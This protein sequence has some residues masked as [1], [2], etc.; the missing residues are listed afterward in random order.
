MCADIPRYPDTAG[1]MLH[2]SPRNLRH[3]LSNMLWEDEGMSYRDDWTLSCHLSGI[4]SNWEMV[5]R[6]HRNTV[7]W[8]GQ[9]APP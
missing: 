7:L 4:R 9:A 3:F 2:I 1:V 5:T 8:V 6:L